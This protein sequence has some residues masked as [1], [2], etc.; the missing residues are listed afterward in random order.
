MKRSTRLI[1]CLLAMIVSTDNSSQLNVLRMKGVEMAASHIEQTLL[2]LKPDALIHSLS[3]LVLSR[4]SSTFNAIAGHIGSRVGLVFSAQKVLSPTRE[5]LET[6][7]GHLK[8]QPFFESTIEYVAGLHHYTE[9]WAC[10]RGLDP[11]EVTRHRRLLLYAIAGEGITRIVR[12]VLGPTNPEQA[13]EVAENSIRAQ[14]GASRP[15]FAV[16]DPT[17]ITTYVCHNV[18]HAS[19]E[20]EQNRELRLWF[21]PQDFCHQSYREPLGITLSERKYFLTEGGQIA[22]GWSPASLYIAMP[23]DMVWSADLEVLEDHRKRGIRARTN[24]SAV[25]AKYKLNRMTAG[26]EVSP[27]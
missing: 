9:D 14:H 22:N 25:V 26:V 15:V 11:A 7:Y 27:D 5:I 24:L 18:A 20:G 3:G 16:D 17:R 19:D 2:I 8:A 21:T 12:D 13:K 10:Q 23:G 1:Q 4:I 6:H